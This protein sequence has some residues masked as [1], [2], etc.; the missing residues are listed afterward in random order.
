MTEITKKIIDRFDEQ[1]AFLSNFYPC[2]IL[3]KGVT[4]PA[5]ENAYQAAKYAGED[6]V[7][8]FLQ[9]AQMTPGKAKWKGGKLALREDWDKIKL[10][11]M[12]ELLRIKFSDPYLRYLL[13]VTK[14]HELVEGN[15]WHDNFWGNCS[16]EK[17]DN[18]GL[19]HLG[20]LLMKLRSEYRIS[21]NI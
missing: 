13:I 16:C 1:Y 15:H 2:D 9:F 21:E 17:C 19:N 6:W 20:K 10:E 3:Y 18:K 5:L 7:E 14:E 4:F 11:V 12:E 8:V